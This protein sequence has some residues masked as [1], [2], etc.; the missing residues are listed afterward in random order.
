MGLRGFRV[1]YELCAALRIEGGGMAVLNI[2]KRG[3][4]LLLM[5]NDSR[6]LVFVIQNGFCFPLSNV[7]DS[8]P[9]LGWLD[10]LEKT[11][12]RLLLVISILVDFVKELVSVV[13]WSELGH[14]PI[15]KVASSSVYLRLASIP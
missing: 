13:R 9:L 8:Q 1:L 2:G 12:W 4:S 15:S 5:G 6:R 14:L 10:R 11:E 7:K 3:S